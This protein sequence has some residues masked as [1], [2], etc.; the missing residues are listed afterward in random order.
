[1]S[2]ITSGQ[3]YSTNSG[4]YLK[5]GTTIATPTTFGD[6]AMFGPNRCIEGTILLTGLSTTAATPSIV[7]DNTFFPALPAGQ[8][9]IEAVE[10]VAETAVTG[11]TSFNIGLIQADRST[12]PSGYGTGFIAAEVIATFAAAGNRV[13]YTQGVAKGGTFLGSSA[14]SATGPYYL[15][16]FNTGA[17][18]GTIRVRIFYHAIGV[19]TQ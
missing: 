1:M 6:Y 17:V 11:G 15:T 3:A 7:A 9:F 19:I 5:F 10:I 2:A 16:A 14:A 4:L 8:L 12:I 13:Y 18:T